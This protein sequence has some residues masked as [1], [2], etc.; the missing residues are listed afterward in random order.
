MKLLLATIGL[1][2]VTGC[3]STKT[4]KLEGYEG[5]KAMPPMEVLQLQKQ[6][7]Y[8]KMRPNVEF[9]Q[10]KTDAGKTLVAVAVHCQPY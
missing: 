10:A 9:V 7:I 8:S 3:S 6:C 5:P 2:I 1:I 4:Y